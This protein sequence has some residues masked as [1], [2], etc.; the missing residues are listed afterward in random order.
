MMYGPSLMRVSLCPPPKKKHSLR[1]VFLSPFQYFPF[2]CPYSLS[3]PH[4]IML[5]L[6]PCVNDFYLCSLEYTGGLQEVI[7]PQIKKYYPKYYS[8]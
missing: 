2:C 5:G 8:Y 4:R 3:C 7:W 1:G 6:H